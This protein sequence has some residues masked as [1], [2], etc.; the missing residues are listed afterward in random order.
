MCIWGRDWGRPLLTTTVVRI[1][2]HL[3][4]VSLFTLLLPVSLL[5]FRLSPS[6]IT[7]PVRNPFPQFHSRDGVSVDPLM[8]YPIHPA[9]ILRTLILRMPAP[10]GF[11]LLVFLEL[12]L[13]DMMQHKAFVL[14]SAFQSVQRP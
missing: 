2:S 5:P 3:V 4:G 9:L 6:S 1:F 8:I 10:Q 12:R 11:N 7:T 14:C 13:T